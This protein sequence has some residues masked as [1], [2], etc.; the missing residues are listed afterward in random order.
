MSYGFNMYFKQVKSKEDA[1]DFAMKVMKSLKENAEEAI[2]NYRFSIPS[3][4]GISENRIADDYWLYYI[5]TKNF[6]YWEDK[7]LVGMFSDRLPLETVGLFDNEVH[8]QNSTDQN[9]DYEDWGENI[10]YFNQVVKS[11]QNMNEEDILKITIKRWHYDEDEIEE[12]RE[13]IK[14]NPLYYYQ[15]AVYHIIFDE[16]DLDL[17]MDDEKESDKFIRFS[18]CAINGGDE[19][20]KLQMIMKVI[21]VEFKEEMGE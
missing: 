3:H 14:G 6:T 15:S 12:I 8:F 2:R 9:Y 18:F 20:F 11:V 4:R 5:F 21:K 10:H 19:Y 7:N 13:E 17:W 1:F 16:L